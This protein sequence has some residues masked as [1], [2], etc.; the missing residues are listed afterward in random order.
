MEKEKKRETN[1]KSHPELVCGVSISC[2][3]NYR[4]AKLASSSAEEQISRAWVSTG[5][6]GGIFGHYCLA[7]AY[8][9]NLTIYQ[10]VSRLKFED[11][12]LIGNRCFKFYRVGH[13][14]SYTWN[15][16]FVMNWFISK[17][18]WGN[19]KWKKVLSPHYLKILM[20]LSKNSISYSLKH[21]PRS[22]PKI[23][24]YANLRVSPIDTKLW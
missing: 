22:I 8:F 2:A 7:L 12:L 14:F 10:C 5:A 11:L 16:L 15:E 13:K 18:F 6:T 20:K 21:D 23:T 3:Q 19:R 4:P 1:L 17:N 9:S 24:F